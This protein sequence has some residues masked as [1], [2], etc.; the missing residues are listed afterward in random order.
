MGILTTCEELFG[1]KDLYQVLGVEKDA[2]A[3]QIKKAYYKISLQ[4]HPDRVRENGK[5]ESTK[6]FQC[7][8]A[9]YAVLSDQE[10]RRI[11]NETGEVLDEIEDEDKEWQFKDDMYFEEYWKF[12]FRIPEVTQDEIEKFKDG[13]RESQEEIEDIKKAYIEA[14]GDMGHIIDSVMFATKKDADRFRK[15]LNEMIKNKKV[16]KYKAFTKKN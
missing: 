9:V 3:G 2:S 11:Y 15:I 4:V 5:E 13:Y 14:E 6:K 10:R 7:L 16:K 1:S 8:G 12:L